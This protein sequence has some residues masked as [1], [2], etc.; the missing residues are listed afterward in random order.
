VNKRYAL[1]VGINEYVSAP[2]SGCVNDAN[3]W[4]ERLAHEGYEVQVLIDGAATKAQI[5]SNLRQLVFKAGFGDRVVFTFSGHGSWIADLDAD[6]LDGRDEVLCAYDYR[7]GGLITD[8]ELGRCFQHIR[9]GSGALALLDS[10]H[11]GTANRFVADDRGDEQVRFLPPHTFRGIGEDTAVVLEASL[12]PKTSSKNA[13]LISGCLDEE[14]SWD[15]W[16]NNRP[17]GAFTRS[18]I[19]SYQHGMS[20]KQW[21]EAIRAKLPSDR[22]LQTPNLIP[23]SSYRKYARA[24]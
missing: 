5:L 17:N 16:F 4:A 7:S 10:C 21:H 23:A 12:K 19:D 15:A 20:L 11:S 14:F 2:L 9:F 3:D 1:C 8:D 13:S 24:L 18:A 22:Y 6:E